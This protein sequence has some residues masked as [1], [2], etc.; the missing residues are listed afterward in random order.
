MMRAMNRGQQHEVVQHLGPLSGEVLE[1][2]PGPGV[3]LGLLAARPEV[4]GVTGVEPSAEMRRLVPDDLAHEVGRGRLRILPGDAAATGLPDAS[5][6]VVVSVNTVAIWPDLDAGVRELHRVLRS[7]GRLVLTWHGG[8]EP[9]QASRGLVLPEEQLGRIE[10]AMR[11]PF[12]DV[13]RTHTRRCT[14]FHATR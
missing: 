5:V 3:L 12:G 9:S 11:G 2:G 10:D 6:D 4:T 7:G 14:V 13:R 1:V 8:R